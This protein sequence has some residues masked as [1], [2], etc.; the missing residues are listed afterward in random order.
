MAETSYCPAPAPVRRPPEV[1]VF[2]DAT[3]E[4]KLLLP[5]CNDCQTLIWYPRPFCPACGSLE[6]RLVR[7]VRAAAR[8]TASRSIGAALAD[9]PSTASRCRTCWPTSSWTKARAS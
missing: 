1:K 8:S 5:Q 9:L 7:G 3:A 6:H 2:W 4:G